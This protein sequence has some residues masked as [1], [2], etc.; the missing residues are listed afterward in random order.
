MKTAASRQK[1][2][3]EIKRKSLEHIQ[4]KTVYYK[5]ITYQQYLQLQPEQQEKY[6]ALCQ[7]D[8]E[9]E[10]ERIAF[11]RQGGVP[12]IARKF[13]QEE[14]AWFDRVTTWSYMNAYI[15]SYRRRRNLLKIDM[16]KMSNAEEY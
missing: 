13:A 1:I 10:T 15:P 11:D 7:K 16:L 5:E 9:Q 8:F 4:M 14:V 3:I 6:L 2:F 12:G